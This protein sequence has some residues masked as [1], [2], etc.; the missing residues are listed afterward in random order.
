MKIEIIGTI[1]FDTT[2][3]KVGEQLAE[4]KEGEAVELEINSCGGDVDEGWA[5]YDRLRG[6]E[7]HAIS[8][9]VEGVCASMAT[10]VLCAAAKDARVSAPNA[11]FCVHNPALAMLNTSIPERFT[12]EALEQLKEEIGKRAA[13]MAESQLRMATVLSERTGYALEAMQSLMNEDKSI[14]A[15]TAKEIGLISSITEPKT[16]HNTNKK[17][18]KANLITAVVEAVKTALAGVKELAMTLRSVDGTEI[19][20]EREDG[21]PEVGDTA[22]PDGTW[23]MEDGRVIT[24]QDGK[25][26]D[27]ADPEPDQTHEMEELQREVER[28]REENE[29]LKKDADGNKEALALVERAGGVAQLTT[30]LNK[31]NAHVPPQRTAQSGVNKPK[32][33]EEL[34]QEAIGERQK[35]YLAERDKQYAALREKITGKK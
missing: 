25:I 20:I 27:I 8:A 22:R 21:A 23:P 34:R 12:A 2:A 4:L 17:M 5:I 26:V 9:K 29:A 3:K 1:G 16:A 7:G 33:A 6:L 19:F 28:L 31:T 18:G 24:I 14:N 13:E 15:E 11:S 30:I 10:V 32:T 35:A